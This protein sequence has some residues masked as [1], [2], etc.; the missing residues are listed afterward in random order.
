MGG[1]TNGAGGAGG[2]ASASTGDIKA[3][4]GSGVWNGGGGSAGVSALGLA[5]A[6]AIAGNNPTVCGVGAT[7]V[8]NGGAGGSGNCTN[9]SINGFP[10]GFPGGGGGASKGGGGPAT[11][12]GGTGGNGRIVITYLPI[13]NTPTATN[14]W[15]ELCLCQRRNDCLC[16]RHLLG[17]HPSS[18]NELHIER[19]SNR[20]LY[21]VGIGIYGGY[22]L[23]LSWVCNR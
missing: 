23:L 17:N 18:H 22:V 16:A 12:F 1:V 15:R 14:A 10:G 8:T 20:R 6:T 5:S 7:A 19:H 4:G 13:I 3:N 2:L 9:T 11:I 21:T